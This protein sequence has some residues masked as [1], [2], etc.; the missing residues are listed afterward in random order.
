MNTNII[1]AEDLVVGYN[2]I[3]VTS[4]L[5]FQIPKGSYVMITGE[6][7]AGKTTLI[8]TIL[9]LIQPI[10]GTYKIM[11]S[12]NEKQNR[13]GYLPQKSDIQQTFP[14]NVEE[15]VLSGCLG[16]T[17]NPFYTKE[18]KKE[19]STA[20]KRMQIIN[21]AKKSF[22]TLSGGQQQ[23]VLLARALCATD[24]II[25]LDEP[26]TGLDPWAV[27]TLY[28][29]VETLHEE[30]VTILMISHEPDVVKEYATHVLNICHGG[31]QLHEN[32]ER[33]SR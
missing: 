27:K 31:C 10:F 29:T 19:A 21:L 16:K 15:I 33:R 5:N 8:K 32:T 7:G 30:G 24:Q 3:P 25:L 1:I 18:E 28:Q 9:G 12:E 2:G 22:R 11:T 13:I 23:R 14:A 20:L 6:N 17:K 4:P 26:V